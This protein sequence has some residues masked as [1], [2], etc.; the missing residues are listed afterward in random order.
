MQA[1]LHRADRDTDD[2]GDLGQWKSR[3]V[4]QDEDRAMLRRQPLEGAIEGVPVVDRDHR[5]GSARSVDRQD[6][7]AAAPAPVPT[8][9]LVTGIDEEAVEPGTE[10]LRVAQPGEFAP[11]EEECL[12]DGVLRSIRVAQDPKRDRVAQV[13]VEVD[14]LREGDVVT[15]ACPLDQP[16]PHWRCSLGARAGAS[17]TT[18]GRTT[19]KGSLSARFLLV[20]RLRREP[21]C[22]AAAWRQEDR[23]ATKHQVRRSSALAE[24][25]GTEHHCGSRRF[26][27][28]DCAVPHGTDL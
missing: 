21:G 26:P 3:M 10:A 11:G 25:A 15:V 12:L 14:E 7:D 27:R 13:A 9:L 5:V 1:G 20:R 16:R 8:R 23:S 6:P 24:R 2:V 28:N 4:V 17:P 22:P 19:E 18:D